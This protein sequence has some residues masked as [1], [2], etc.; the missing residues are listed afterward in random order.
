MIDRGKP[1]QSK[2]EP[3]FE[4]I[5]ATR[6][7]RMTW[8]QIAAL[9]KERGTNCT[10][11]GVVSF[12]KVRR[13]RR[14]ADGV[15]FHQKPAPSE[16]LVSEAGSLKEEV[17]SGREPLASRI[18]LTH[19]KP[20][21]S[22]LW[23]HLD[24]IRTLRRKHET[25]AAIALHLRESHGLQI[26]SATVLKFFKRA[27]KGRLP[28]G[29]TDPSTSTIVAATSSSPL[30]GSPPNLEPNGDPLL[31]EISANDPFANLKRKYERTRKTNR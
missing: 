31:I 13:K 29:F 30:A 7:Q 18:P 1:I 10:P 23:P 16:D 4:L 2:L 21:S 3:Y 15:E 11:Q 20:Y 8:P 6:R 5:V 14:H 27:A 9:I 19:P 25:W 12:F 28:I 26:G 22:P 24:T 17:T